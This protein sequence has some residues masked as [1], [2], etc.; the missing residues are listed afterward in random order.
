MDRSAYMRRAWRELPRD[1]CIVHILL[2][3]VAGPCSGLIHHHHVDPADP[4]SRTV[5]VCNGHHQRI[6]AAL[7]ALS[8]SQRRWKRCRHRHAYPGAR[9]ACEARLNQAA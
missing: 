5:Q 3:D 9:A 2:G 6:H 1:Y 7:R 8:G 4:D